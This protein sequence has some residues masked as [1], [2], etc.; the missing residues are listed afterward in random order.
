[1]KSFSVS[2]SYLEEDSIKFTKRRYAVSK[3]GNKMNK[4]FVEK[5]FSEILL[6]LP[7]EKEAINHEKRLQQK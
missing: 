5:I 6:S 4:I 2:E 3:G 1:M 7:Q